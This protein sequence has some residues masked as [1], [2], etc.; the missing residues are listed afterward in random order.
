MIVQLF[1]TPLS[2]ASIT[3]YPSCRLPVGVNLFDVCSNVCYL[4]YSQSL[5]VEK[6]L[7]NLESAETLDVKHLPSKCPPDHP[8]YHFYTFRHTHE[9][10]QMDTIGQ[11]AISNL[12]TLFI[13]LSVQTFIN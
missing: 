7:I 13:Q 3:L 4:C 2:Q 6:E 5:D 9:G 1:N 12:H 10:D 8:R 11:S